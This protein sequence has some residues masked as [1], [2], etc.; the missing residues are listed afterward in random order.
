MFMDEKGGRKV[1]VV[2]KVF[3]ENESPFPKDESP[4]DGDFIADLIGD[5]IGD[6]IGDFIVASLPG[7]HV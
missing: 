3:T 7:S 1:Q 4:K 6:N 2:K 5:L